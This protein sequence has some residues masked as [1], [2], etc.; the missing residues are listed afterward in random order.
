MPSTIAPR[1][2]LVAAAASHAGLVRENNEDRFHCDAE[3]G[4][5]TVIDGVG[6]QAA[7][8]KAAETAR[9]MIR[10][11]LERETGS[12]AER[13]REAITLANNEVH[14]LAQSDPAW[15]GMACVLTAA[16]VRDGRLTVGHVGDTRLYICRDGQITKVTHDHSPVGEREDAGELDELDAMRHPRRNEIFRDVGSEPHEPGDDD[17]I[18]VL[19]GPF[20]D[21]DALLICTDGLTD[22][23]T[24]S[25][26]GDIV[27]GN[28][29]EPQAVV[30][31]LI[32]AANDEG[33]K[34]NVTAVFVAGPRFAETARRRRGRI[35]GAGRGTGAPAVRV[36]RRW[37]WGWIAGAVLVGCG[38]GLAAAYGALSTIDGLS[39]RLLE[40]TRPTSWSRTW[41]VGAGP[42]ADAA[43]IDAALKRAQR[44]DAIE[45]ERGVYD[46]PIVLDRG[47]RLVSRDSREAILVPRPG[48]TLD[49]PA[50]TIREQAQLVGFR[51]S[52]LPERRLGIG[53]RIEDGEAEV[54]DVEVTAAEVAA[55]VFAP[56]SRGVLRGSRIASNPGV[57]V[58]VE[59]EAFPRLINNV[60][61]S[62]GSGPTPGGGREPEGAGKPGIEIRERADA[63]FSGN[64]VTGQNRPDQIVGL[65]P[66]RL[67][68]VLRD[69]IVRRNADDAAQKPAPPAPRARTPRT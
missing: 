7:G 43:T 39:G 11:R 17:F 47:I 30:D 33:G 15:S 40:A 32:E 21:D 68:E 34:D 45:V 23:V 2:P 19:D 65:Q 27:Y 5:F 69:N 44:G 60:V 61:A 54:S 62:N 4:L 42:D 41:R 26:I 8:E 58:I 24:S 10:A 3:R 31:R 52:G 36:A 51:I 56:R 66:A 14:H 38:I 64:I 35:G 22:L 29:A 25:A 67:A 55:V 1:P 37:P 46:A 57:G 53:V 12:P 6:G 9:S 18:E 28:A 59:P 16:L 13:L 63:F 49:T 20:S 48:L 50:V